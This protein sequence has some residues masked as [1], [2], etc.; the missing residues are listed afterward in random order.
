MTALS[1]KRCGLLLS[2]HAFG[3]AQDPVSGSQ[4]DDRPDKRCL[5]IVFAKRLYERAVELERRNTR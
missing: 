2:F 1:E 3:Y 5:L 4:A